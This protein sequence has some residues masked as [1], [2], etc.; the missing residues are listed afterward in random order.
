MLANLRPTLKQVFGF[1][2]LGLILSLALLFSL[3]LHG[4]ERTILQSAER[5]R[6]SASREVIKGVTAYLDEAPLAVARFEEQVRYGLVDPKQPDSIQAGL[7]SLLL[8]NEIVSEASFTYADKTGFDRD[9]NIE[10]NQSSAGQVMV[11][12]SSTNHEFVVRRTSFEGT[13]FVSKSKVLQ[14]LPREETSSNTGEAPSIDPTTHL[15][16]RTPASKDFY[17]RLLWTDLHW[18]Q[19]NEGLPVD[20]RR[21][22]VSVQK[23]IENSRSQFAGV[24]R[25]GLLKE[26]LDH[27]VQLH[28]VN[29]DERDPHLIFLCDNQGRLIT[30]VGKSDRVAESNDDL[31]IISSDLQPQVASALKQPS[32]KGIDREHP[33]SATSFRTGSSIYLCTFRA[34]PKTQDWIVGIVVPRDFYLGALL[35]IRRRVLWASLGLICAIIMVGGLIIHSVGRAHSLIVRESNRM[36]AFEFSPSENTSRLRDVGDVLKG[37]EKAKAAMRAMGKYVPV[38]LV[39]QLYHDGKEPALGGE[40][41]E[42]SVLFTDIKG[43]TPFAEHTAP[44]KVAEILGCYL[45]VMAT[46]I[47]NEKGTIDKYIGDAVMAFWN[48]PEPLADHS[49]LACRAALKCR[50]ELRALYDSP[51]WKGAL[52][53]ETR[54]GLHRCVASVGHF[55]APDRFNYTAIGD[56]INLASRLDA[57]N[58]QYGTTIIASESIYSSAKERFEFR[59]LDR[60]AVKG[61]VQGVAIYE[62]LA[63]QTQDSPR[64]PYIQRYEQAFDAYQRKDFQTALALLGTESQDQPTL[65]LA[66]RCRYLIK[67]P[68]PLDWDGTYVFASK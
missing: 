53:F 4:S 47:Q 56:G 39:R 31:R 29:A 57:L 58:N 43:F 32:L 42:L 6:D 66:N 33:V 54:F 48:A 17:G 20:Q 49:I 11:F 3:V 12:R 44:D 30:A 67:N 28:I 60:V 14:G 65:V 15:T 41:V 64:P 55:G 8:A 16:F 46:V 19:L 62:L 51:V 35:Q 1:G 26:Q 37:L 27:V 25:V 13:R 23:A 45:Q 63:E 5:F 61:K 9:G 22:E 52:P 40:S 59:L 24:L 36:N 34:L 2:L 68:P 7:L 21:V 18:S 10:V 50:S 38:D